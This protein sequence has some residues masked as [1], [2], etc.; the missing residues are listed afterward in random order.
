MTV[1]S[2]CSFDLYGSFP[3]RKCQKVIGRVAGFQVITFFFSFLLHWGTFL[4]A[5]WLW[6][7]V[8]VILS[9]PSRITGTGFLVFFE[10]SVVFSDITLSNRRAEGDVLRQKWQVIVFILIILQVSLW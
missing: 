5:V 10:V 4:S 7:P 6:V 8:I 3:T 1:S 2:K 9:S